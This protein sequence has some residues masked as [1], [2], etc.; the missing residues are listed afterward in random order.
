MVN[1]GE[2]VVNCMVNCGGLR[3]VFWE[4]K[5]RQLFVFFLG[6]GHSE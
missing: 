1:R 6:K 3:G 4:L 5:T 2:V